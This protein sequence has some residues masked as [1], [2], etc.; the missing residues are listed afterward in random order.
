MTKFGTSQSVPRKEDVRFLTGAGPLSRRRR[1]RG[2]RACASSSAARWRTPAIAGLDVAEAARDLPGVLAVF[3]AADLAGRLANAIDFELVRN[4]DGSRGAAPRRPVLADDARALR[5]RGDRAGGRRDPRRRA[6]RAR[7]DRLRLRRSAGARRHRRWAAPTIH[8]EAP[9]NLAYD[10]AFGDEAEVAAA[11]ERAAHTTRLEL[12]DNR[13]MA[14]PAGAARLLRASGTARGCTSASPARASGALKDE[15]ADKL[16]LAAE[17][18]RVTTPDVGGGFGIKGCNYP[19]YFAVAFAARELGRPVHWMSARG[20]AM[21][22]DNGGRDHVTVAEAAFDAD[23]RLQA[24]RITCVSNLGAYNSPYG[25]YIASELALKVMPGRLRRAAGLLRVKGVFTNTTPLDAY[26]GAGRPEAIYVIER[27]MDWSARDL[28]LDPVELRRRNFIPQRNSPTA[29]SR[30]SSTT[31]AISTACWTAAVKP[32]PTSPASRR[33]RP[34]APG[35]AGCA[36]SGSATTSSRS[37]ATRT[38]R[39]TIAFAEDGMVE[40]YVGTQSNGQGHETAFAQ[41]LHRAQPASPSSRSASSR[42]TATG[43]P[44]AAAPAARA[45]RR[46]RAIRS[47]TPPTR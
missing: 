33:A 40:L 44:R 14:M 24:L 6:R 36:G 3:T 18:V 32:R 30:A 15:L 10:W 13:V 41:I 42:A 43:S 39:T 38:R 7:G 31:S 1:A 25:Q 2:R 21:L 46:C 27:L 8:P 35:P 37:S 16:G 5:R 45:R 22:T 34:R 17:A 47:T 11:F 19:E 28:G 29:P 20:E 4:R 23:Y 26:R 12:I 9:D